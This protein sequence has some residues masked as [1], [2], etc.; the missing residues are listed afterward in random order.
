MLSSLTELTLTAP[1]AVSRTNLTWYLN[2]I[3]QLY[4]SDVP[5]VNEVYIDY[6]Y[7]WKSR[8][9]LIRLSVDN[10]LTFIGINTLLQLPQVPDYVLTTTIAHELVHYTHGFGSPLPRRW[11]HPHAN[12]VVDRELEHRSLGESLAWC[13]EWID[14]CWYPFYDLQRASGWSTINNLSGA[15]AVSHPQTQP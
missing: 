14:Q 2:Q 3:W 7:P 6:C 9:G 4:F 5:R 11:K 8:L 10:S 12:H 1:P 13:N 15:R